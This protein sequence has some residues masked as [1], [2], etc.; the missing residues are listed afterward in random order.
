MEVHCGRVLLGDDSC[1]PLSLVVWDPMTG[2]RRELDPPDHLGRSY[3]AAVLCPVAGCDHRACHAGPFQVVF[4]GVDMM[5][6]GCL[7]R[8]CVSLPVAGG[9]SKPCSDFCFNKWSEPCSALHLGS[10]FWDG[11]SPV[12]VEDALYFKLDYFGDDHMAILKYDLGSNCLSLIDAPFAGSILVNAAIL[13]AMDDNSLGFAHVDKVTLHLWSRQG[14]SDGIGSW[15]QRTV[16]D[17]N[18]HL[19]I[20]NP[21][22]RFRLIGSLEGTDIIFVTMGLDIYEINL[23]TLRWK[24]LQK[25]EKLCGL[26]PYMSFYNPQELIQIQQISS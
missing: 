23:K 2:C 6:D 4:I 8:A 1:G 21:N 10:T 3:G 12:S 14:G 15:T 7:V 16:I 9:W 11:M 20:Q 18:N 26:I 22:K 25:R 17:L 19:P 13:M 5:E 24:K